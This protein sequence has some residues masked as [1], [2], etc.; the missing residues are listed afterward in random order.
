MPPHEPD[1]PADFRALV[2]AA[3]EPVAVARD[4]R[5]VFANAAMAECFGHASP[6]T[7]MGLEEAAFA[8]A[9]AAGDGTPQRWFDEGA[10]SGEAKLRR[11]DGAPRVVRWR[12]APVRFAGAPARALFFRD[13]TDELGAHAARRESDE[14]FRAIIERSPLAVCVT[15]ADR[16]VYVNRA[17]LDYLGYDTEGGMKGPT[18]AALSDRVVDPT[19]RQRMRDAFR[20]LFADL[21]LPD[22]GRPARVVRID[23]VRLRSSRDGSPR[24]CDIHGIVVAHDGKPALV[25]YL[26]DQTERRA[27][28][29]RIRLAD[30]M[31]SL[32]TLAAGVAHEINNPLT[33]VIGNVELVAQQ[34]AE[35][36]PLAAGELDGQLGAART[37]L[38]RIRKTVR[39]LKTFSR[40]DEEAL[41]P[42]DVVQVLESCIDIA[43]SQLR[44]RG[45]IVRDYADAVP[46]IAGNDARLAQV[47]LNLL[48]NAAQALD[49]K[50]SA[51]N[52][53]TARVSA[54][55]AGVTV[56]V[57]DNGRG[58]APADLPRVFDPF[59]TTKPVGV[60]TGLGL[61]VCHGIVEALGGEITVDSA[62]GR[63]T[64]VAVRLPAAAPADEMPAAPAPAAA[65]RARILVVDDEPMVGE[66][67]RAVLGGESEVHATASPTEALD[68]LRG[69]AAYDLVLCDL[70]MPEMS[71]A[72]LCRRIE[73]EHPNAARRIVF[74]TGGAVSESLEAYLEESTRPCLDKPFTPDELKTFVRRQLAPIG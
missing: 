58:I 66:L 50:K 9:H 25:T 71:G 44:H 23:D 5:I 28:A 6:A 65:A 39:A 40:G 60:G 16:V 53:V 54:D 4:G 2:E 57:R 26:H 27:H 63:G 15:Q 48:V 22:A 43:A 45:T 34:L 17:M 36:A 37:G 29:A 56:E 42:V 30:R 72:E 41:G 64:S 11:A 8:G 73:A 69:P 10:T 20:E 33:Y 70:M 7:V 3:S 31:S 1:P 52:R 62:L 35:T 67:V 47:F 38:D 18:L 51:E 68:R 46:K 61:F 19:D 21:S 32:G 49:E 59:F 14:N 13:V 74:M 55:A 12:A 24:F